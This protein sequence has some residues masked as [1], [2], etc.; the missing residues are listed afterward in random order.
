MSTSDG[1]DTVTIRSEGGVAQAQFVPA[2]NMLCCSLSLDGEELLDAG[3]GVG[4]YAQRGKT[5]GIPLL[6]PW[7]NRLAAR[8]YA[9][10][11]KKVTLPDPEGRYPLDP[12]GLPIHGALPRLLSWRLDDGLPGDRIRGRLDWTTDELLQL[13]PFEH[14]LIVEARVRDDGLELVTTLRATGDDAVPVSFGYHPYLTLAGTRREDWQVSLGAARRL[15]LDDQMLPTGTSEPIRER[16]FTLADKSF[17]D[18]LVGLDAPPEFKVAADRS[19]LT[20]TFEEGYGYG[21]VYAPPGHDFICFEPMTALTN[22][23]VSGDGLTIVSPG[24]EHRAAFKITVTENS[25]ET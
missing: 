11:G 13:F 20:V 24:H 6:H 10:A 17:D 2:A 12:N 15:V 14:E 19:A 25:E 7:A 3:R 4:A 5:M 16:Q 21:Q 18:G 23:L 8:G 9:A 1:Y 22:A